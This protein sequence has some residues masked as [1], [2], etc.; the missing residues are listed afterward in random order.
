MAFT[1]DR[2]ACAAFQP[3]RGA[4]PLRVRYRALPRPED[5]AARL[6]PICEIGR[7][8]G[9]DPLRTVPTYRLDGVLQA[10]APEVCLLPRPQADKPLGMERDFWLWAPLT[11]PDPLPR[12]AFKG[13]LNLWVHSLPWRKDSAQPNTDGL[14]N[15]AVAALHTRPPQWQEVEVDLLDCPESEGGTAVPFPFQFRLITDWLARRIQELPPYDT[16]AG[17][18]R[19]QAVPR[20]PG[21]RGAEL[22]SNPLPYE[23]NGLVSWYSVRLN[24]TVHSV[25]FDPLPRIH[26]H[27]GLRRWATR[28]RGDGR[29]FLPHGKK[30]S[31][32]L[33]SPIPWLPGS[34]VS[35]R[36]AIAR[37]EWSS[38]AGHH[39]WHEN[40]PAGMLRVLSLNR[41]SPLPDPRV[42]LEHPE[43]WLREGDGVRAAVVHRAE[44]GRHGVLPGLMSHQRS[45]FFEWATQALPT[46]L[47]RVPALSRSG[48]GSQR[49]LN[50]RPKPSAKERPA[51]EERAAEARR[52]ALAEELRSLARSGHADGLGSP[53]HGVAPTV[54]NARLLW[55]TTRMRDE[56]VAAFAWALGLKGDGGTLE[57]TVGE[58]VHEAAR[59]GS[60]TVLEWE[61]PQ[62]VVRLRCLPLARGLADG[63]D[64]DRSA[65]P[66][67]RALA[68]AIAWRRE[69]T[70]GFLS[71]D[72]AHTGHPTLAL[73]EIDKDTFASALHDPKYALRLGCADAGVVSQFVLVPRKGKT[74][75]GKGGSSENYDTE[76][77]AEHRARQGWL[78]GF[79]QLGVRVLPEQSLSGQLPVGLRYV[80]LWMVKRRKDG[81]TR[82]GLKTPVAVM[83]TPMSGG[84]GRA[85]I[86]GWDAK[87]RMWVPYPV[88][89]LRLA[90][91]AD[92]AEALELP[93][94]DGLLEDPVGDP[95]G[96]SAVAG[97]LP[98]AEPDNGVGAGPADSTTTA[99]NTQRLKTEQRRKTSRFIQQLLPTLRGVPTLLL[100]QAQN[101]R[102]FWPWLQDAEVRSDLF[103]CGHAPAAGLDPDLRLVRVRDDGGSA[104][105]TP[106]WWGIDN[107][108]GINGL[109]AGLWTQPADEHSAT[110][111]RVFYSTAEKPPQ[112]K[113]SAVEAN[114]LA[115]RALRAGPRKG[116][117]TIDTGMP[118][119]N[120]Q[121]IELAVLG[122]HPDDGD[123]AEA[124]AL[125]VHQLRQAPDYA[126]ALSLPLPLH[127]AEQ[128]D[129][130][131]L[132]LTTAENAESGP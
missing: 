75:S 10:L 93:E 104:G 17:E 28:T 113:K 118:S 72:G 102:S 11:I 5:W 8:D 73:V 88:L 107:P 127:L 3:V 26:L 121:L 44:M 39:V 30:T 131:V 68:Q 2:I 6:L 128:A 84:N 51:E 82:T 120:P 96:E 9:A 22:V 29:L 60:A 91:Y 31:V 90:Q 59:P 99:R 50:S 70:A 23:A 92:V 77:N 80:G 21:D 123:R 119:W 76:K 69:H 110:E 71:D 25:P 18:L 36:F 67:K 43:E 115:P 132:P 61:T 35:D 54:L 47:R 19:F 46:G 34:P 101:L 53:E 83:V 124:L 14:M 97:L 45:Q 63:L 79:R 111:G 64:F 52:E 66:R 12:H 100:V 109:S 65:R 58:T 15:Q 42:L 38:R 94:L 89:L 106:Q 130:Y 114:K 81:P 112:F 117:P 74:K 125:A 13:L 49:P 41:K 129:E 78:D 4:D 48:L 55:Q 108:S 95:G 87:E 126:D 20:R 32:Y 98:R 7:P 103:K 33:R 105:E 1:Y 40:D 16:G 56:A 116:E 122:C 37:L 86:T 62:L 27:A 57:D 85:R 24:L